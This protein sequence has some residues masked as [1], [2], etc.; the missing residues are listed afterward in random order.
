MP[1]EE[2]EMKKFEK[3]GV[4]PSVAQNMEEKTKMV[5]SLDDEA[6]SESGAASGSEKEA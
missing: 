6:P 4:G 3:E 1:E 5:F 2:K